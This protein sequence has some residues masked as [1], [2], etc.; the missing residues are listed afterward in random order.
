MLAPGGDVALA[1]PT[2]APVA[3]VTCRDVGDPGANT[4]SPWSPLRLNLKGTALPARGCVWSPTGARNPLQRYTTVYVQE[5]VRVR[6]ARSR[7]VRLTVEAPTTAVATLAVT[8]AAAGP[9]ALSLT[10]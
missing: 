5:A 2:G 7:P 3:H 4:L 8:V 9:D 6:P 10:L 1:P